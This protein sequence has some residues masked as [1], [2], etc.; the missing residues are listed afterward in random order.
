MFLFWLL[1]NLLCSL[2]Y[3]CEE[4]R[5][6]QS[7]SYKRKCLIGDLLVVVA[8]AAAAVAADADADADAMMLSLPSLTLHMSFSHD[9]V[10]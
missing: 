5:Y 2:L 8:A 10:R 9:P 6:G 4:T 1:H 7:N 3:S